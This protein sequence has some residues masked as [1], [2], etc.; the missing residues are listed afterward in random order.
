MTSKLL[1][2]LEVSPSNRI[3]RRDEKALEPCRVEVSAVS[4]SGDWMATLDTREGEDSFRGEVYL[5]MWSWDPPLVAPV[6]SWH[7]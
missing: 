5:K 3:S 2:E 6:R 4:D 7:K 1:S